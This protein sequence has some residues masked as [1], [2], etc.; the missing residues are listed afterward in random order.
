MTTTTTAETTTAETPTSAPGAPVRVRDGVELPAPGTWTIDPGHA[1]VAF[2]GRHMKF[3]KVRGSFAD[4]SGAVRIAENPADSVLDV[5]IGM[6]SVRSGNAT[7][8]DHLRSAEL[9]DVETYPTATFRSVDVDWRGKQR[10]RAGGPD[11]RCDPPRPPP[12]R[13]RGQR[14]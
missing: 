10:N 13:V 1:D 8:D 11:P 2:V 6:A 5:T 7:R 4:V 9:F 12:C 14:A 3:T